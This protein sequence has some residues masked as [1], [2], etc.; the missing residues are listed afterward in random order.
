MSVALSRCLLR[1]I[2]ARLS[3]IFGHLPCPEPREYAATRSALILSHLATRARR[4][5]SAGT[6]NSPR[7]CVGCVR[8]FARSARALSPVA[9][10]RSIAGHSHATSAFRASPPIA[11]TPSERPR[12]FRSRSAFRTLQPL[13][14]RIFW[15]LSE[16]MVL[17]ASP[18]F[19]SRPVARRISPPAAVW[20]RRRKIP[21]LGN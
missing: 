2:A 4:S 3:E 18:E 13:A 6:P 1:A 21:T 15:R 16:D 5:V 20:C 17:F 12:R 11:S 8:T 9:R 19:G 14:M 10:S 7:Q